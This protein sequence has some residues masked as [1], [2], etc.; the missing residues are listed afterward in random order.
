MVFETHRKSLI[1]RKRSELRLHFEWT[2]VSWKC[3]KWFI[4]VSEWK[5]EAC[6]QTVLPDRSVLK[7]QKLVGNDKIQTFKCDIL[8]N[9]QTICSQTIYS[10]ALSGIE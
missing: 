7:R 2:K 5:P 1:Q 3:Q 4:L 8:S 6:S 9:F 10:F